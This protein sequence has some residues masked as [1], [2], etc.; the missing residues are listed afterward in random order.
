M[1]LER[2]LT[3]EKILI[4]FFEDPQ[5]DKSSSEDSMGLV[6]GIIP[7]TKSPE[8]IDTPPPSKE[9]FQKYPTLKTMFIKDNTSNEPQVKSYNKPSYD[10]TSN[11]VY[12]LSSAN[13]KARKPKK[14]DNKA[15]RY[16]KMNRELKKKRM[17]LPKVFHRELNHAGRRDYRT[18]EVSKPTVVSKPAVVSKP[19][20]KLPMLCRLEKTFDV[21]SS[22]VQTNLD[23]LGGL[24]NIENKENLADMQA[25]P[26]KINLEQTLVC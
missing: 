7:V 3:P 6:R 11:P 17:K 20:V 26:N 16:E 4:N 23:L 2:M 8:K 13:K 18:T 21:Y 14:G 5:V 19:T 15:L 24:P 1:K 22:R 10:S 12:K 9:S 25:E